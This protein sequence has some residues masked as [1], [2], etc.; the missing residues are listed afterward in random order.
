MYRDRKY[1]L[2]YISKFLVVIVLI[3]FLSLDHVKIDLALG[4]VLDADTDSAE[5]PV[6][7]LIASDLDIHGIDTVYGKTTD[8]PLAAGG[9]RVA[10]LA[11]FT[12]NKRD[13]AS[14]LKETWVA[15]FQ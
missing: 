7:E 9:V 12:P 2:T 11:G 10:P 13:W 15:A 14:Y 3:L 6:L 8:F 1:S 5:R 4:R